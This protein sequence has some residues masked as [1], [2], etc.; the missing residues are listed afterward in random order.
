MVLESFTQAQKKLNRF[1]NDNNYKGETTNDEDKGRGKR[2]KFKNL[3][4]F[5]DESSSQESHSFIK[6]L[7]KP[8]SWAKRLSNYNLYLVI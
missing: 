4:L 2:Q 1:A 5:T 6:S 8:P 7:P 3:K